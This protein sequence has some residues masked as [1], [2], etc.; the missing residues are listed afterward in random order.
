MKCAL[1]LHAVTLEVLTEVLN[2]LNLSRGFYLFMGQNVADHI[3]LGL[4]VCREQGVFAGDRSVESDYE[5]A[6]LR[7]G[8]G[9]GASF[10]FL[11][12][13]ESYQVGC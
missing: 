13:S 7:A 9:H 2:S 5:E 8:V 3:F 4:A 6:G 11:A 12:F 10:V 1:I